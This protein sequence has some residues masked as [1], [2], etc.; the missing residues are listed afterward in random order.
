VKQDIEMEKLEVGGQYTINDILFGTNSFVIN[1]T[2]QSILIEFADY[3][4]MSPKLKVA[5]HGHTDNVGNP[6]ANVELSQNRAKAVYDF[7]LDK[8]ISASRLS[9]KGFGETKPIASN[10][11]EE[12]RAKNRRTVFVVNSQ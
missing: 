2:I 1:D 11:N 4:K 6:A 10:S 12:G 3:L 5:L 7:L 8:G 9:Y